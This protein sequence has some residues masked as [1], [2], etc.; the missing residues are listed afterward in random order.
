MVGGCEPAR[1]RCL[2]RWGLVKT[3]P[4]RVPVRKWYLT[5]ENSA[6]LGV[7]KR[8]GTGTGGACEKISEWMYVCI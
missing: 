2:V 5:R 3:V 1:V 8:T 6:V 7:R 4:V